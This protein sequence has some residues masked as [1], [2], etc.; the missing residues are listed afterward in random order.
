M[1]KVTREQF[2]TMSDTQVRHTPTRATFSTYQ[3]VDP[4]NAA[5]TVIENLGRAG[6]TLPDGEEYSPAEIRALAITLLRE[7]ALG[8]GS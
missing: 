3:Y 2:E 6:E 5:N 4:K 1:N 7:R 8:E